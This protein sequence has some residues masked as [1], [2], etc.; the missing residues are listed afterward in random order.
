MTKS[1]SLDAIMKAAPVIPVVVVDDPEIAVKLAEALEVEPSVLLE[2]PA[3][4][5]GGAG[6]VTS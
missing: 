1:E 4:R 3:T 6:T 2:A 5:Q